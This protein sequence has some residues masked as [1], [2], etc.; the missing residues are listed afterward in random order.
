MMTD[1]V[2]EERLAAAIARLSDEFQGT[3]SQGTID[4]YVHESIAALSQARVKDY[5]PVLVHRFTRQRLRA[6]AYNEGRIIKDRP[7]V[8]FVCVHNAG[9][10][11]IAAT[12]TNALSPG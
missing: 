5:V 3:F 2:Y 1:Q 7:S 11:Q 4:R 9:R 8:L 10:S 12:L 6:L